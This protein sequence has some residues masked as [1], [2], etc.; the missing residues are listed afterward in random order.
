[1]TFP[2][3]TDQNRESFQR[4]PRPAGKINRFIW[5]HQAST[6][7]DGTI[8]MMVNE[9]REVSATFTVDNEPP[10]SDPNRVWARI[11][12]VVPIEFRPWTSDSP[13]ADGLA[14]TAEVANST[15]GPAWGISEAT[16]QA[17]ARMAVWAYTQGV[18]LKRATHAD[19][20]GHLGHNEVL[21]MFGQGYATACPR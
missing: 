19:P 14:F 2:S 5:H 18:P 15:L 21:G 11:T 1:M 9:T 10:A 4:D 16:V 17:C 8:D 13:I 3:I 7:D 12:G 20:S 6:N